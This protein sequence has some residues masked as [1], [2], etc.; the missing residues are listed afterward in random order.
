MPDTTINYTLH[1]L[2]G[3]HK[4]THEDWVEI[5]DRYKAGERSGVLA[6]EF[7]ITKVH[8]HYIIRR[9]GID[10]SQRTSAR[11]IINHNAFSVI[12]PEGAYWIG[13]LMS[14]GCVHR[15]VVALGLSIADEEH[16]L[17]F[18]NFVKSEHKISY[19]GGRP[20]G[21]GKKYFSKPIVKC[22]FMSKQIIND[23]AVFGVVPRKSFTAKINYLENSKDFWRGMVDGD[24]C[25][26]IH[27]RD[28]FCMRL[29]GSK[30]NITQFRNFVLKNTE[31]Y[32]GDIVYSPQ[33]HIYI[34]YLSGKHA[35]KIARI[36]YENA[37]V[38]LNRKY[39]LVADALGHQMSVQ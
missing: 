17:K 11:T 4:L 6:S 30:S 25:V 18:K 29:L 38:Y 34:L 24:G 28:G 1:R 23:L 13:M 3:P 7:K 16:V 35:R 21:H 36:L 9:F 8:V 12:T 15:G 33:K 32:G 20:C 5:S 39:K 27:K 22:A 26:Y 19:T 10:A 2:K 31:G 37:S 14:D